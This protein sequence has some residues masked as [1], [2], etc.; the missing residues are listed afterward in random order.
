MTSRSNPSR[1]IPIRGMPSR[2][3]QIPT[4]LET[5]RTIFT[6]PTGVPVND[7]HSNEHLWWVT[8]P[9]YP[10]D[11]SLSDEKLLD[12]LLKRIKTGDFT[13]TEETMHTVQPRCVSYPILENNG[14][15][16]YPI[17]CLRAHQRDLAKG[18]FRVD[19]E[20]LFKDRSS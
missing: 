12:E 18:A 17:S 1:S 9:V 14:T 2:S 15:T 13:V 20:Y 11:K 19:R 3:A 5:R 7:I 4:L 16:E 8:V 6:S 10:A